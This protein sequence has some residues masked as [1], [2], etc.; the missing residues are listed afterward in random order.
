VT[1]RSFAGQ[2]PRKGQRVQSLLC[3]RR[4]NKHP[5]LSK[6]VKNI[7]A[8]ASNC[9]VNGFPRQRIRMQRSKYFSTIKMETLF[10]MWFVPKRFKQGQS[11]SAVVSCQQ[12]SWVKWRELAG[13]W[14]WEFSCSHFSWKSAC[15]EKTR[16]LEWNG[17]QTG[18]QL[19]E[20]SVGKSSA[21]AGATRGP[22]RGKRLV[23]LENT[24][25]CVTVNCKVCKPPIA[26]YY[27]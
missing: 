1:Y 8:I 27:L 17:R 20:L 19:S 6:H 14:V 15:E 5:F 25:V 2:R 26:L 7:R 4:K 22:E 3:N 24:S 11:S 18:T 13:W 21:Q 10:S 9:T 16:T 23:K 12:F